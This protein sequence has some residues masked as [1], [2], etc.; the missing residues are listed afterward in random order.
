MRHLVAH[1]SQ[2]DV[3]AGRIGRNPEAAQTGACHCFALHWLRLVLSD[4]SELA[5]DRMAKMKRDGGGLNLLLNDVYCR[6][7]DLYEMEE[8]DRVMMQLRGLKTLSSIIRWGGYACSSLIESVRL[9][10]GGF[11]YSFDY[12]VIDDEVLRGEDEGAH[13]IAFYSPSASDGVVYVFDSNFG[14]FHMTPRNLSPFWQMHL[15]VRYG[16]PNCHMLRKVGVE[17]RDHIGGG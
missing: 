9:I 16:S 8:S 7:I 3:M 15:A 4:N 1:F 14:E 11:I 12:N 17:G 6:R 13:S 2:L 5:T 10:K